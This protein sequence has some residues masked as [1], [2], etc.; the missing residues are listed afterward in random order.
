ML[1][2][3]KKQMERAGEWLARYRKTCMALYMTV[4]C[5]WG[6]VLPAF[7]LVNPGENARTL[8]S[9]WLEPV[10]YLGLGVFG[11]LLLYKRKMTEFFAFVAVAVVAVAL[12]FFPELIKTFI[13]EVIQSILGG[14]GEETAWRCIYETFHLV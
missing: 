14:G 5:L 9:S 12:V 6:S 1:R 11:V 3:F 13:G 4:L 2:D 8:L 10:V 7:A